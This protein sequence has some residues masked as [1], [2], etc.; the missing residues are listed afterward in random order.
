M[1]CGCA[2]ATRKAAQRRRS[3]VEACPQAWETPRPVLK[4]AGKE[5]ARTERAHELAGKPLLRIEGIRSGCMDRRGRLQACPQAPDSFRRLSDA[6][7]QGLYAARSRSKPCRQA[8]RKGRRGGSA[9]WQ[10]RPIGCWARTACPQGILDNDI[11]R[12]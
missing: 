12:K 2:R 10:A 8:R 6:C 7:R 11:L 4:L 9:C 3:A 5:I 1:R